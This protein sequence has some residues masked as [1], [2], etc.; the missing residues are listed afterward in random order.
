[1]SLYDS[2][3]R[4]LPNAQIQKWTSEQTGLEEKITMKHRTPFL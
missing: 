1:M 3:N 2:A 4:A